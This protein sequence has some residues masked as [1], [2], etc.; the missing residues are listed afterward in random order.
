MNAMTTKREAKSEQNVQPAQV[1]N[2]VPPQEVSHD[3][4]QEVMPTKL[5]RVI[6]HT[7][8]QTHLI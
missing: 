5:Y 7:Q 8:R 2:Y 4:R 1:A 6:Q 3:V